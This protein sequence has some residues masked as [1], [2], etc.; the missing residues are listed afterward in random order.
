M[1]HFSDV[2]SRWFLYG[3]LKHYHDD[4]QH[5]T[6]VHEI[7]VHNDDDCIVASDFYEGSIWLSDVWKNWYYVGVIL[8]S[9]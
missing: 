7:C 1:E 8:V 4:V 9:Q 5:T 2:F 3:V 6:H